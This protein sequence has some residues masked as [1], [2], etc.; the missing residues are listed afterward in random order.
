METVRRREDTE[1]LGVGIHSFME[2][3]GPNSKLRL[4]PSSMGTT[5]I[6]RRA[7]GIWSREETT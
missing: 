5:E 7:T 3:V 2:D 6:F 1:C 4:D